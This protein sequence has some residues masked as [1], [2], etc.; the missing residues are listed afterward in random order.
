MIDLAIIGGSGLYQWE[1]LESVEVKQVETPFGL[2]SSDIVCGML[3]DCRIAFLAR[4][5]V[6][7]TLMPH[8]VNY[9]ANTWAL[10]HLQVKTV[11][12]VNAVGGIHPE[13][14]PGHVTVVDQIIDYSW[15][16][17]HTFVNA[18][19]VPTPHIDFTSPYDESLRKGLV[20]ALERLGVTHSAKGVYGC[21]QGPRL[22]TAA[23]IT[24]LQRDGC[25]VVGMTGMP[26]AGLAAELGMP[27][28][29][30]CVVA[31]WAAGLSE[32]EITLDDI[33]RILDSGMSS[34]KAV[35]SGMAMST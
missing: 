23:E 6:D 35:I 2:P 16:R 28:A 27:Y 3:G 32:E 31:N 13:M 22:E 29:S 12:G 26:E 5:G 8:E 9:R 1:G 10:H 15:G 24:R 11:V 4:H 21:T 18:I 25:D 30:L 17:E 33:H 7:H 20:L 14:G 19:E 34:V